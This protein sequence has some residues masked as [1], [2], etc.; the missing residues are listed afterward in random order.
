MA[1]H[2]KITPPRTANFT[3][4]DINRF[5]FSLMALCICSSLYAATAVAEETIVVGAT[6]SSAAEEAK[7]YTVPATRAGTKLNLTQRDIPQSVSVVTE[8]RMKDQDLRDVKDILSNAT[9][10]SSAQNDSERFDY[11]SR[12]F[13]I[14]NFTWDDIPVTQYGAWNFGETDSDA[15]IYQ[16]VDI[17]RGSAGLMTGTGNPGAAI[18]F[19]RKKADSKTFSGNL[20]ASYGSWDTQRYVADLSGPL[21]DAGTLRGRVVTG[22]QD[23]DSWM[24]RYHK[25]KKFLYATVQADV[26]DNTIL[27]LGY[28]YQSRDTDGATWGGL[29][30]WYSNGNRTHYDHSE[31]LA[32]D[33]TH[34]NV[35]SRKVFA[36]LTTH[37]ANGWQTRLNG[38]HTETDFDSKLFY[39]SGFPDRTTGILA[40]G[41]YGFAGWYKGLRTQ[42]AVD[43]YA[44]GPF[45]LLGRQHELVVGADYSRQ[46]NRYL[47][48]SS[49]L[50]PAA[51]GNMVNFDGNIAEPDWPAWGLSSEDTIRQKAGYTAARFS[52]ADPLSLILGARYTQY[53]SNGTS[54]NMD[55]NNLTPYGGL[56]Y[57]I[58][59]N[60]SAFLSYTAIFQPQTYRDRQGNYLK[61][62]TG[63]DYEAGIKSD[64]YNGRLTTTLSIFRIEQENLGQ[65]DSDNYVNNS[66]EQAYVAA[67][68]VVSRGVD[69]EI[70]GAVTDNLNL[71]FGATRYVA[72]DASGS[73]T[74]PQLPQTD[75][76][77]FTSYNLPVMPELTVG[78]GVNWQ[79]RTY[80]DATGPSGV[81]ERVYQSSYPLANLFARYEV[82]KNLSVQANVKNLFDREY[83]SSFG[84]GVVYGE[85]LN[86]SVSV[87]YRF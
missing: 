31:S 47:Y 3:S 23:G 58:N 29:P 8:E 70:N 59:E 86:Y 26:T 25:S 20:S 28:D 7:S 79:N 76:K 87:G 14:N 50:S 65:A 73:R 19:V 38:T 82:N 36:N 63:R 34:Y 22:Y 64:W 44:T 67:K 53:S 37:F 18:N 30:A 56:V 40:A 51:M 80:K 11:F 74:N 48:S 24:D 49:M 10:I 60:Y 5:S 4:G 27:D 52:L 45:N 13:Y 62:V 84:S 68:G 69:F 16:Q 42:T 72:K 77:L 55:K 6:Q 21:N 61:P 39:P 75:L 15:A 78:G 81:K 57:D 12:G 33:W 85:P 54:A 17:V 9:G 32:P 71:T 66:S 46:R 43:A 1:L 83:Y 35:L 41:G 2:H